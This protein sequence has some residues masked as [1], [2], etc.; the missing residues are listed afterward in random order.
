MRKAGFDMTIDQWLVIKCILENPGIIQQDIAQKVFK[1]QASVTRI[2]A[3][4]VE[5]KYL[6]R[7]HGRSDRRRVHLK[8]TEKGIKTIDAIQLVIL[9]N[10]EHALVGVNE[11]EILQTQKVLRKISENCE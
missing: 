2:I 11:K 6:S 3:L 7:R 10:R 4:L 1:D 5:R 8:V 9:Q